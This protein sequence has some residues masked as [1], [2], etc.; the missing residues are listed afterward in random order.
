M[1]GRPSKRY[2]DGVAEGRW[3]Q[4]AGQLSALVELDRVAV[5][6][7]ERQRAGFLKKPEGKD[8]GFVGPELN[9]PKYVKYF[10]IGAGIALRKGEAAL[11]K[12]LNDAIKTIRGNGTYAKIQGKYF[13][14]DVYGK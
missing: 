9:D 12:E 4:D 14:F 5:D 10:G 1:P 8:Y 11:K 13:N 3:T 6:L 7:L 2:L